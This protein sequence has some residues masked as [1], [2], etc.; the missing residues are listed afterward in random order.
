MSKNE[1]FISKADNIHKGIYEYTKVDYINAKA[2]VTITCKI[3]GDFL[4]RPNDHLNGSGCPKCGRNKANTSIRKDTKYFIDNAKKLH[5]NKYNYLK[6]VY[7]NAKV[8][9]TILCPTHGEFTQQPKHHLS[10]AGCQKCANISRNKVTSM[11]NKSRMTTEK[12]IQL[13]KK[14]YGDWYSY[15]NTHY[16]A[17]K[18]NITIT[19]NIHGDFTLR[20][21]SHLNNLGGCKECA[22]KHMGNGRSYFRDKLTTLYVLEL[23]NNLF[24][25]GITTKSI[26]E[27]YKD[28][29]ISYNVV[30]A[31]TFFNGE[32]AFNI[33]LTI[34]RKF[35]RFGYFGPPIFKYTGNT[36]IFTCDVLSDLQQTIKE[37]SYA[38]K[39]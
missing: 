17:W 2:P 29:K 7:T 8:P 11:R 18:D 3:H 34:K 9:V 16:T 13:S 30:F 32:D 14:R 28:D 12:F 6:V 22:R 15:K 33:E 38:T 27:R 20:A 25:I 21:G 31:A 37:L 19:C 35:R 39:K 1:K 4:Q 36:E 26:E 23:P 5:G 24:K 10:G